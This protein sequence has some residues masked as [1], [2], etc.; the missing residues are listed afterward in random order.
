MRYFSKSGSST[1]KKTKKNRRRNGA[2]KPAHIAQKPSC[3]CRINYKL[4]SKC[5]THTRH[6]SGN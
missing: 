6:Q 2:V 5:I 3:D 4:G 1:A